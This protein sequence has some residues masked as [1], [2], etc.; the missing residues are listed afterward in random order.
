MA[1]TTLPCATALACVL[2]RQSRRMLVLWNEMHV[3][4]PAG[5][6][7]CGTLVLQNSNPVGPA[8]Y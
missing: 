5:L 7:S 4:N 3:W 1:L 8:S 2:T 6:L